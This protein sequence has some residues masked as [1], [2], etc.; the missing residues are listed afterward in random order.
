M[1]TCAFS[2]VNYWQGVKGGMEIHGQLLSQGLVNRGHRVSIISTRHPEGKEIEEQE[3]VKIYYLP[4]TVFGSRRNQWTRESVRKFYELHRQ[5]PFDVIWSQSFA[6]YGLACSSHL[7]LTVPIIPILHGCIYQE[8]NSFRTNLFGGY[9]TPFSLCKYFIGLLFSYYKEQKPLLSISDRII[10]VSQEL[11]NDLRRWY[12][13][14]IATK[15]VPVHNGIDPEDFCPDP[16]AR[17]TIRNKFQIQ[18]EETLLMTS[19]VLNKEKGHHLAIKSLFYLQREIPNTK[20]MIVGSGESRKSLEKLMRKTGLQD[21]VL[22]TGFVPNHQMVQYYNAADVYLM[23]TLRIE[24][25]P[26]VLLEAMSCGKPVVA[27]RAGGNAS[28]VKHGEN[29]FLI[30]PGNIQQLVHYTTTIL[31]DGESTARLSVAARQTIVED[32]NIDKMVDK[33]I[34]I[35]SS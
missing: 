27:T 26:F 20:L 32:F 14:R 7:N 30:E 25:L 9:L 19:G 4:N 16:Q 28:L 12:G 33:T 11:V 13:E 23:P 1:H 6:A 10:T 3:G 29:G 22:F 17:H 18:E 35:I 5:D 8:L 15:A 21:R 24:G 34:K 31:K 2:L